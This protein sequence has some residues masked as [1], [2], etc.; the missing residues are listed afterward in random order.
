MGWRGLAPPCLRHTA[1]GRSCQGTVNKKTVTI[2]RRRPLRFFYLRKP[3]TAVLWGGIDQ[4]LALAFLCSELSAALPLSLCVRFVWLSNFFLTFALRSGK[5]PL[6]RNE[7]HGM[8]KPRRFV[9]ATPF[10]HPAQR[11]QPKN[12]EKKEGK[13]GRDAFISP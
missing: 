7:L 9:A 11:S 8:D 13:R 10:L 12:D 6:H 5:L 4:D 3:L 1:P 2:S